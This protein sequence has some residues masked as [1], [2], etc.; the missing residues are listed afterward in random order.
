MLKLGFVVGLVIILVLIGGCAPAET[1]AD[2][3]TNIISLLVFV[4]LIFGGMYFL[5]VRPQ[6]KRQKA[7]K[8]IIEELRRGD[9]VITAGGI[10]GVVERVSEET[11]DLKVESGT[12][13]R[14]VRAAIH[15]KQEE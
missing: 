7:Q 8:K 14:F 13:I 12:I 2:G 11:V 10:Y 5:I 15:V 3:G 1:P 6:R 4:V 9:K